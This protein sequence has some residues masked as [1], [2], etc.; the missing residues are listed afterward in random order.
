[1]QAQKSALASCPLYTIHLQE[2]VHGIL[3]QALVGACEHLESDLSI[4]INFSRCL[5]LFTVGYQLSPVPIGVVDEKR[6]TDLV[7]QV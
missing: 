7:D 2:V 5:L 4:F 6:S 3:V 1:M